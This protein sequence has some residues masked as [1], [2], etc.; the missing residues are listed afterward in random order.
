[1][2]YA[3]LACLSWLASSFDV[4]R[5][6]VV[7]LARKES[8]SF[9]GYVGVGNTS[10]AQALGHQACRSGHSMRVSQNRVAA[11]RP[12]INL[13]SLSQEGLPILITAHEVKNRRAGWKKQLRS[14]G[15]LGRLSEVGGWF[16]DGRANIASQF[17]ASKTMLS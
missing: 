6:F 10:I 8:P 13:L 5:K 1:L 3:E 7:I 11:D 12:K 16:E 17:P 2:S 14:G 15:I 9:C 4:K